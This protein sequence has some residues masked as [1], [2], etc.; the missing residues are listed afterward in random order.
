L[1]SFGEGVGGNMITNKKNSMKNMKMVARG[2][3][4]LTPSRPKSI[5]SHSS[6]CDIWGFGKN[7][8]ELQWG[9]SSHINSP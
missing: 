8:Q 2:N 6:L 1:D 3:K 4:F 7:V 9:K 5:S